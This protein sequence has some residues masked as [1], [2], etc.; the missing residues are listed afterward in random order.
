[1]TKPRKIAAAI[2][3][4]IGAVCAGTP[5]VAVVVLED[6][7]PLLVAELPTPEVVVG[8]AEP[9]ALISNGSL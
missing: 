6:A 2:G 7:A 5:L 1:M 9:R 8:Y 4:P 3:K